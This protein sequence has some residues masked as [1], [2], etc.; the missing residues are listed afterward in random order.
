MPD[1]MRLARVS[2]GLIS[3]QEGEKMSNSERVRCDERDIP[4]D[5]CENCL[6]EIET[7]EDVIRYGDFNL[8]SQECVEE[9]KNLLAHY[10]V[11]TRKELSDKLYGSW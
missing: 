11:S 6:S 8:C 2:L 10:S 4:Y 7:E 1:L 5:F 9:F 3:I